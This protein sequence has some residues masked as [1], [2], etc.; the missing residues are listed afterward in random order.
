MTVV[1]LVV[2]IKSGYTVNQANEAEQKIIDAFVNF[3]SKVNPQNIET[4]FN[5]SWMLKNP[6]FTNDGSGWNVSV[7]QGYG[8]GEFY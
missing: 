4:P 3:I 5:L 6:E 1:L 2:M 7:I 8:C